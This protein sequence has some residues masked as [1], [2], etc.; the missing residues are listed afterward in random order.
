[1]H[2]IIQVQPFVVEKSY[3]RWQKQTKRS[4]TTAGNLKIII[5][6][7]IVKEGENTWLE[8]SPWK[9]HVISELWHTLMLEKRQQP[10]VFFS[11]QDVFIKLVKHTKVHQR[12]TGWSRSRSVELQLHLLQQLL[13]GKV[14]ESTSL[15]HQ[16]TWTLLLK[17][18]GHSAYLMVQ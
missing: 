12:W 8:N 6:Q 18:K 11:I 13:S 5:K 1:M 14:I 17:L 16:V 2:R 10:N 4:L 7:F 15:I 9:R 3:T